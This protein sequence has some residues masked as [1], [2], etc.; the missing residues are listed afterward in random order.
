V[1]KPVQ[2]SS[3]LITF[4]GNVSSSCSEKRSLECGVVIL[5]FLLLFLFKAGSSYP[6]EAAIGSLFP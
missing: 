5:L 1:P 3:V 4:V 2:T 6:L